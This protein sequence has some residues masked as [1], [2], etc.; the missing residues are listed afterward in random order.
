MAKHRK[1]KTRKIQRTRRR[2]RG[3]EWYNPVSWFSKQDPNAQNRTWG[4]W[5][6]NTTASGENAL[7]DLSNNVSTGATKMMNSANQLLSSDVNLTGSQQQPYSNPTQQQ[8]YSN[9]SQQQTQQQPVITN[10]TGGKYKKRS[11]SMRGGK[12]GLGLTYY[13]TPVSG[14]KVVEPDSWQ[15]YANGTNQ[16]S[17]KG[18]SRRTKRNRRTRKNNKVWKRSWAPAYCPSNTCKGGQV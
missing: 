11:R 2:Q 13:A 5:L 12:S 17:V 8:P 9:P 7:T 18:G 14:L 6:S 1:S 10:S 16:Y 15:Y 3:G 4:Q